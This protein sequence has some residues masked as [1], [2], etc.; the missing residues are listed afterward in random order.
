[1]SQPLVRKTCGCHLSQS[2]YTSD[3]RACDTICSGYDT[4]KYYGQSTCQASVCVIDNFTLIA[5]GSSVGDITFTQACPFC[6]GSSSCKCIIGD[7]NII[8]QDSR[9][10]ALQLEQNCGGGVECYADIEGVR[11]QLSDCQQYINSFGLTTSVVDKQVQTYT[12]YTIMFIIGAIVLIILFI[13]GIVFLIKQNRK[14]EVIRIP[15]LEPFSPGK[16]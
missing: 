1:M 8:A 6:S 9:M 11:T 16:T 2:Q 13:I 4:I 3:I 15:N 5:K 10:G 12:I 7:I 14:P